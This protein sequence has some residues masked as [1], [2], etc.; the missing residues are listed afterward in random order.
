MTSPDP[1]DSLGA[2]TR[3]LGDALGQLTRA[4][5]EGAQDI[6]SEVSSQLSSSLRGASRSLADASDTVART[7]GAQRRNARAE[8]TREEILTAARRLFAMRGYEGASV[9]DIAKEAGFTKGALY[10]NFDS[11]ESLFLEMA[12][13]LSAEDAEWIAE[14]AGDAPGVA[15][16]TLSFDE[17]SLERTLLGLE[18]W[19]YAARHEEARPELSDAWR[20]TLGVMASAVARSDGREVATDADLDTAFGLTAVHALGRSSPRSSAPRRSLRS[21]DG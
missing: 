5:G 3:A 20:R 10:A 9:G 12:R 4:L 8:Q 16:H 21:S 19:T 13:S 18:V 1:E 7:T 11:K 6:S 14:H 17:A 15:A 2:A